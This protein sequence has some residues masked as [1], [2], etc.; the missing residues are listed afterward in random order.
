M[1][2]IKKS[3]DFCAVSHSC[4]V[5]RLMTQFPNS[6][7][8]KL[9]V[10]LAVWVGYRP[11][12]NMQV[13]VGLETVV[14]RDQLWNPHKTSRYHLPFTTT[15]VLEPIQSEHTQSGIQYNEASWLGAL[16]RHLRHFLRKL[17]TPRRCRCDCWSPRS[18]GSVLHHWT[19]RSWSNWGTFP[20]SHW[21]NHKLL[22]GLTCCSELVYALQ[23]WYR[24]RAWV[25]KWECATMMR[26]RSPGLG[27]T[28]S[29][30]SSDFR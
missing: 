19:T 30:I 10:S 26:L 28:N 7:W 14:E 5:S 3:M 8:S 22:L 15:G 21:T 25:Q 9:M 24:G 1:P 29:G 20:F 6:W 16:E 27:N 13:W 2:K 17:S 23:I 11:A 12:W 4:A 18:N